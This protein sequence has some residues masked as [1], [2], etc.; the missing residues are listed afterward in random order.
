[1]HLSLK[2]TVTTMHL[3][4]AQCSLFRVWAMTEGKESFLLARSLASD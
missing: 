1:M 2:H 4:F 3:R